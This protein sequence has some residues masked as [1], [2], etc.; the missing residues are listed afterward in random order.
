[1]FIFSDLGKDFVNHTLEKQTLS[2][3]NKKKTYYF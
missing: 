3:K 2:Y 1:M